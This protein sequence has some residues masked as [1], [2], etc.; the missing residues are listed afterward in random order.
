MKTGI[1]PDA[2][3]AIVRQGEFLPDR[4]WVT[5]GISFYYWG[6]CSSQGRIVMRVLILSADNFED[7][8][9]LFPY[10]RFLEE[11]FQVE[12]ASLKKGTI[13]GNHGY[14]VEV[15]RT[16]AE[17]DPNGYELLLLPGGKAPDALRK[18][19]ES[20]A[21]ARSFFSAGKPVAAI[22]HGP[23]ILLTA[24]LLNGRRATCYRS[25]AAEMKVAGARYEDREV[26]VDGSL[27]TS[28]QPSDLPAFMREIM[29]LLRKR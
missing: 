8:E 28:R 2:V 24:G 25:L 14:G 19:P 18:Q 5:V 17:V 20:L 16:L 9:L 12:I 1:A 26:V 4:A 6:A 10:Y 11:N 27:I 29:Q 22:C 21:I 15:D 3:S 7:S 13:T 23:Q